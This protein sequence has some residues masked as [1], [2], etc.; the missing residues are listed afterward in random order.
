MALSKIQYLKVFLR[1]LSTFLMFPVLLAY[2]LLRFLF[3]TDE[4]FSGVSQLLSLIPGKTGSYLRT[5]FYRL[6]MTSCEQDVSISFLVV[7]AQQDTEIASGVYIGPGCNIGSSKIGSNTLLGS[8]IHI[9]S[10]KQQHRFDDLAI[11][12]KDQ[13]GKLKKIAIGDDCWVG[14]G[15]IIMANIGNKCVIGA[16]SVVINDVED[17]SVMAG[18]PARV[19][20]SR[21][22]PPLENH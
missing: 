12:I 2:W 6:T 8:G 5:A 17:Y 1:I 7:F 3:R 20:K 11:S 4:L 13:P 22:M 18:N 10:G 14:N 15:A 16:G 9:M 21:K 19:I